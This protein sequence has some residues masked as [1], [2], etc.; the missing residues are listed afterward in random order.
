[1]LLVGLVGTMGLRRKGS[2]LRLLSALAVVMV[3][4]GS[5]LVMTACA[6]PG[7]YQPVLTPA[8]S[9]CTLGGSTACGYPITVTASG[10]GLKATTTVYFVVSSPGIPGQE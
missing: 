6:G 3:L 2:R 4:C 10:A 1:M 8:S 7:V 5:S 9:T